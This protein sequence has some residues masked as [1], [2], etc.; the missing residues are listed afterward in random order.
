MSVSVP[1]KQLPPSVAADHLHCLQ[2]NF[3]RYAADSVTQ[4]ARP[5]RGRRLIVCR[6]FA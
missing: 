4:K 1:P 3:A 6:C 5:V 2:R